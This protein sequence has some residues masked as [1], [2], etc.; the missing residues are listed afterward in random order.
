MYKRKRVDPR[1]IGTFV[2]GAI[3]LAVSGLI[4][5]GP[6]GFFSKSDLYVLY[7]DSSVKGLNAGSPVR[8][9]GVKIGQ[10]KEIKV[11]VQ[12]SDFNFYI[13][14]LIEVETSRIEADGSGGNILDS[15]KTTLNGER[16]IQK[17][18][19]KGLRARLELDSLVTAQ[20]YV[21]FDMFPDSAIKLANYQSEY[22]ELPTIPSSFGE[23]TKTLEDLPLRELS[24]KLV[25]AVDGFD[26]L[27]S[28]SRLNNGIAKFDETMSRLNDLLQNLNDQILPLSGALSATLQQG[29]TTL[30]HLD[31]KIDPVAA[32]IHSGTE[33]LAAALQK[34]NEA[35]TQTEATMQ[36]WEGLAS[37]DS[38]V[39]QEVSQALQEV[40]KAARSLRYLTRELEQ[41]P[42]LL[43]RG[44]V[45]GGVK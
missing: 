32:D 4:F 33:S 8:F 16:P 39:Q 45:E 3:V 6:G 9:R 41:D 19:Q 18:V 38:K 7:F 17:L 44:R 25:H 34:F 30:K 42:Q 43:L 27:V 23:I 36:R 14:V 21:N 1:V 31:S 26:A 13:P 15:L 24:E 35:A 40:R 5:F 11:R 20:L 22:L 10:V 12:P 29:Q 37:E 28:S 2:I